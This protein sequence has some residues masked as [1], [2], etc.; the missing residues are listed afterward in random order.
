MSAAISKQEGSCLSARIEVIVLTVY[1]VGPRGFQWLREP[2]YE[3]S[4][5]LLL[6][7]LRGYGS[8]PK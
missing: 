3:G 7:L 6:G 5:G 2:T 4:E 8:F 1:F